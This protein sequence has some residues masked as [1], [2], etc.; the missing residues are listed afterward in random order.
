MNTN[1]Q[2]RKIRHTITIKPQINP[3]K[4]S[5]KTL[6]GLKSLPSS[7]IV[8]SAKT[9]RITILTSNMGLLL[10]EPEDTPIEEDASSE[11][12]A[13]GA[14]SRSLEILGTCGCSFSSRGRLL[15]NMSTKQLATFHN[16]KGG[17][18]AVILYRK[19]DFSFFVS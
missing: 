8:I 11:S 19:R 9:R 3:I 13:G 7:S 17:R 10:A 5:F 16:N 6:T 1:S 12:L 4:I 14:S 18:K 2:S 15:L